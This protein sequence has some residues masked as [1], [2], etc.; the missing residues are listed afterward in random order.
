MIILFSSPLMN[1][2]GEKEHDAPP[3]LDAEINVIKNHLMS[4]NKP[5]KFRVDV[6]TSTFLRNL[7]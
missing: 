5:L 1:S 6:F 2:T 7:N 3:E 4:E